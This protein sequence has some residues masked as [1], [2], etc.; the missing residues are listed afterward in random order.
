LKS[1]YVSRSLGSD[2]FDEQYQSLKISYK[3]TTPGSSSVDL[4][5]MDELNGNWVRV[6]Y[7]GTNVIRD[8]KRVDEEFEQYTWEIA[9]VNRYYEDET[10]GGSTFFKLMIV[11]E[12][13]YR[14]ERP[15]VKDL[16]VIFKY[17]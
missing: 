7:D 1:I 16:T 15:R 10:T 2:V 5:Y 3:A 13:N 6:E 4:Y 11:L 17:E 9:R 8:I 12:T 14:F